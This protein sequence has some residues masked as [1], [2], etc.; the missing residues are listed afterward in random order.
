MFM[1]VKSSVPLSPCYIVK[2]KFQSLYLLACGRISPSTS[3]TRPTSMGT[4]SSAMNGT[5]CK[6]KRIKYCI[7]IVVWYVNHQPMV[8]NVEETIL[9]L[10]KYSFMCGSVCVIACDYWCLYVCLCVGLP[11]CM[12]KREHAYTNWQIWGK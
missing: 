7:N 12:H 10:L 2:L 9:E 3:M 6:Q 5:V 8:I 4:E 11:T 1:D